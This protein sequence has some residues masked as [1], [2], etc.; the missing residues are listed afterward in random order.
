MLPVRNARL[1]AKN[2]HARLLPQLAEDGYK[3]VDFIDAD[4]AIDPLPCEWRKLRE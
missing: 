4:D 3:P 2:G 1:S